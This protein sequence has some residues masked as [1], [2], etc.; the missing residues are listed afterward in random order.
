MSV[1][2]SNLFVSA[3]IKEIRGLKIN[4]TVAG[5]LFN[6]CRSSAGKYSE[7][8]SLFDANPKNNRTVFWNPQ[9]H[10]TQCHHTCQ[11]VQIQTVTEFKLKAIYPGP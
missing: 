9:W 8:C 10:D 2:L 7:G 4:L 3:D 1:S 11:E 5:K 6:L